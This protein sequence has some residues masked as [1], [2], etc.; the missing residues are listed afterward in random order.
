[1]KEFK[2]LCLP[3]R[4]LTPRGGL[5][6]SLEKRGCEGAKGGKEE[7]GATGAGKARPSREII[8]EIAVLHQRARE[9]T[10]MS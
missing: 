3:E 4:H 10:Q 5:A 9:S 8:R 1:M 6:A 7:G 2:Y